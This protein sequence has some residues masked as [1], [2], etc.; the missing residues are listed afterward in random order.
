MES[1]GC[2]NRNIVCGRHCAGRVGNKHHTNKSNDHTRHASDA[3]RSRPKIAE[4]GQG[5]SGVAR[6]RYASPSTS[7]T[8]EWF[9]LFFVFW[10]N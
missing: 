5:Y 8:F 4:N 2:G 1:T 3:N 6:Y 9:Q 10:M 7:K